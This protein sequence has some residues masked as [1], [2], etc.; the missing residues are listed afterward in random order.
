MSIAAGVSSKGRSTSASS[1]ATSA[2]TTQ[3]SGSTFLIL[4]FWQSARTFTSVVDSKSNIY[5]QIDTEITIGGTDR[6]RAYY[7]EN[8]TGGASHTAT[9]NISGLAVCGIMFLEITGGLTSGSLDQ[10]GERDDVASP[11]TLAAGLTITQAVELLVTAL[12]G[13]S[14]SN[15]ATHAESGL[16]SSAIQTGTQET[17]GTNFYCSAMATKVTAATAAFNPSWTESGATGAATWLIT[18][19][20]AGGASSFPP[21]PE[22]PLLRGQMATLLAR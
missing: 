14:G 13:N 4:V 12:V 6:C 8:G 21:V 2:V 16:G 11:F 22:S 10:H 15:P 9:L 5:T 7:C 18:F 1:I 3:A 17:D 20:D 19:K